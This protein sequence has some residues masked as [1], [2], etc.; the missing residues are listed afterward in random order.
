MAEPWRIREGWTDELE[1][2][3]EVDGEPYPLTGHTVTMVLR[4]VDGAPITAGGAFTVDGDQEANPGLVRY[5][6]VAADFLAS[7][8]P[9]GVEFRVVDGVG[10]IAFF[11]AEKLEDI[12][13]RSGPNA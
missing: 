7:K 3:L 11:P 9:Y 12:F 5:A 6:P 13:V 1:W 4:D 10:K 2:V 8:S